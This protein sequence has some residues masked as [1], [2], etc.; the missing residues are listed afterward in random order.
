MLAKN[1]GIVPVV[2][3]AVDNR[4]VGVITDRDIAIRCV[5]EGKDGTL[6]ACAT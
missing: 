4:L 6:S 3:G 2:D 1:V 5:A